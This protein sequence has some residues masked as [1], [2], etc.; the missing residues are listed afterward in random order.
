M[1]RISSLSEKPIGDRPRRLA[2]WLNPTGEKKF[3]SLVD[4]R[5]R[6]GPDLWVYQ[7]TRS[8]VAPFRDRFTP[9]LDRSLLTTSRSK[10]E[11]G[12]VEKR[13]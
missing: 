3:H 7:L 12:P 2:H 11:S 4:I 10:S 6:E 13:L 5:S 1:A 9:I 8:K